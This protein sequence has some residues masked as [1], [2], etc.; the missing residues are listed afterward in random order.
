MRV[1]KKAYLSKNIIFSLWLIFIIM[2]Y[3]YV[4]I[5]TK[6]C[7]LVLIFLFHLIMPNFIIELDLRKEQILSDFNSKSETLEV[8]R[9]EIENERQKFEAVKIEE[10]N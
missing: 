3:M 8:E 5:V 4:T 1:V 7:V 2:L 6:L 9:Q 10:G